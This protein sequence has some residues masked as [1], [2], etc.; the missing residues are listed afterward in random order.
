MNNK[1]QKRNVILKNRKLSAFWNVIKQRRITKV[2]S[3]LCATYFG[4]F[5]GDVMQALPECTVEQP[6]DKHTVEQYYNDNCYLMG[7][8]EVNQDQVA[9]LISKLSKK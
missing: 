8:H 6:H 7:T 1:Y 2:K 5:H 3:S 9:M 4:E